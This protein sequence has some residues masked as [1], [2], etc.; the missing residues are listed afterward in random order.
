MLNS[1]LAS[2]QLDQFQ[3]HM[4]GM[5]QRVVGFFVV[6]NTV[7]HTTDGLL[8][9]LELGKLWNST[10]MHLVALLRVQIGQM[11]DAE[12]ILHVKDAVLLCAQTLGCVEYQ[13]HRLPLKS[14]CTRSLLNILLQ[15]VGIT[16]LPL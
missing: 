12:S 16:Q 5:I 11:Q 3:R 10:C 9:S 6:E 7:L 2:L 1:D 13:Y 15:M 14:N 4:P 8:S